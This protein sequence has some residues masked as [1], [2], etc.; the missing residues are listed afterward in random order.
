VLNKNFNH[1]KTKFMN[2]NNYISWV[3]R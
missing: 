1:P 2:F 3:W